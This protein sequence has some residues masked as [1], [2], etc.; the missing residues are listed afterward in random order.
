[1]TK[2]RLGDVRL[3]ELA[4]WL[5]ART[6][7]SPREAVT[8]FNKGLVLCSISFFGKLFHTSWYRQKVHEF[9]QRSMQ[10]SVFP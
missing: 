6:P 4:S 2:Q 9:N 1:M 8:M 5:G 7:K 10:F 3:N